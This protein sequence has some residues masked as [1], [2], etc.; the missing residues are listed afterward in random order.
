[1]ILHGICLLWLTSLSMIISRSIH[2]ATNGIY[3][4]LFHGWVVFHCIYHIFF[5]HSSTDGHLGCSHA[6]AWRRQWQTTPVLLP[7]KYHGWRSLVGSSPWG[8][9]VRHD[10]AAS[11]SR[12][13]GGNGNPLQCSCLENP[14]D[15]GTWWVA[16]YGVTQSWTRLKKLSSS[17]LSWL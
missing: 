15:G 13:G 16:I 14:R 17:S 7:G 2:I 5:I 9:W 1:M 11:L 6:L 3:F 4:F 12:I 10:W 8:H